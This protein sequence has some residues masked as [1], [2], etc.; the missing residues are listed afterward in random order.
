VTTLQLYGKLRYSKVELTD[1]A[2]KS[3]QLVFLY[4]SN[5]V[6]QNSRKSGPAFLE[7][8]KPAL[9]RVTQELFSNSDKSTKKKIVKVFKVWLDRGMY[10]REFIDA[11]LDTLEGVEEHSAPNDSSLELIP[12]HVFYCSIRFD[13]WLKAACRWPEPINH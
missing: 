6:L 12:D 4:L 3:K 11:L 7:S 2:S 1:K 5:E 10:Q 8:F 9:Q 13:L